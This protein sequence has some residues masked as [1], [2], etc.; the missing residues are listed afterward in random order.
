MFPVHGRVLASSSS[1]ILG[2]SCVLAHIRLV[3]V[4]AKQEPVP[5]LAIIS[6]SLIRNHGLQGFT[7]CRDH[8]GTIAERPSIHVIASHLAAVTSATHWV[9]SCYVCL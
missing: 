7:C 6:G 1:K 3:F 4:V 9:Q 2:H 5:G 8:L